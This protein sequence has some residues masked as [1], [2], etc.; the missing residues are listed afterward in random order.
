MRGQATLAREA[1][2]AF[3]I[4]RIVLIGVGANFFVD[5]LDHFSNEENPKGKKKNPIGS[6][7]R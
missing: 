4:R 6:S 3:D 1:R 2:Y 7:P 5:P